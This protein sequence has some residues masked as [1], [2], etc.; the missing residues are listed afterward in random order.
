MK[1]ISKIWWPYVSNICWSSMWVLFGQTP[2]WQD[3]RAMRAIMHRHRLGGGMQPWTTSSISWCVK[4]RLVGSSP[5]FLWWINGLNQGKLNTLGW[6]RV[7]NFLY[8][9]I[10]FVPVGNRDMFIITLKID[11]RQQGKFGIVSHP[12][13]HL[14][15]EYWI[16]II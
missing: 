10:F 16:A 15:S 14:P 11:Q 5:I 9:L 13:C 1:I 8:Y 6:N 2:F 3:L 4:W 7:I 12:C